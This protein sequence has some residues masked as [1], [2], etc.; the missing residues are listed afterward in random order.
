MSD[1]Q[2]IAIGDKLVFNSDGLIP[3]IAQDYQS[4]QLLMMA[5]MN[6]EALELTVKEG[7]AVYWSRS[8]S[9]IWRKGE[10]S[11][12]F[13]K[14]VE[15]RTDCDNDVILLLV[16]QVGKIACHTGREHCF[17][18]RWKKNHWEEVEE[19]IKDPTLIY[20]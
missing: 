4:R 6:R 15:I 17:Y 14:L 3:V 12:H 5:W 1:E 13:Q 2:T 16:E 18:R 19:V 20:Q 10:E 11:G 8:R 9:K 7:I